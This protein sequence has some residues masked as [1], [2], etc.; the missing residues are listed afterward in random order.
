M[1]RGTQTVLATS[2]MAAPG[3]GTYGDF[4]TFNLPNTATDFTDYNAV[5]LNNSG[6]VSFLAFVNGAPDS[7]T[8]IVVTGSAGA[9]LTSIARNGQAAAAGGTGPA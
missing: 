6:K 8:A 7:A 3:G 5:Q 4:G 9:T 1:G 2:G